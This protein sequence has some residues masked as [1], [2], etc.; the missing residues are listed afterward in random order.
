MKDKLRD[1]YVPASYF[2]H[3]LD[4]WHCLTQDIKSV[5]DYVA[6]FNEFLI[7]CSI[8]DTESS[9]QILSRFRDGLRENLRTELLLKE[10]PNLRNAYA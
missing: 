3:F 1:K 10:L 9:T 2:D 5:K 7:R 8:I 6:Q 4:D